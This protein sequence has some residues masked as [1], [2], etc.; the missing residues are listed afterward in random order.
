MKRGKNAEPDESK[1]KG[2]FSTPDEFEKK[3]LYR[4][5]VDIYL[6]VTLH[7]IVSKYDDKEFKSGLALSQT[8]KDAYNSEERQ[9]LQHV[10]I[11]MKIY[12]FGT[13]MNEKEENKKYVKNGFENF[14]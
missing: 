9:M 5:M 4:K 7:K 6:G 13:F 10:G 8:T 11:G 3:E 1:K 2:R 14:R 12:N